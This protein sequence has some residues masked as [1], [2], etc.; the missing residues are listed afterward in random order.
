MKYFKELKLL[1]T[2]PSLSADSASEL[3]PRWRDVPDAVD[4]LEEHG[5][6][7]PHLRDPEAAHHVSPSG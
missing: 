5:V 6:G 2:D 3:P 7:K 4:G 1:Q